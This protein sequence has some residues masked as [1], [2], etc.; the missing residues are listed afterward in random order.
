MTLRQD[1]AAGAA[2]ER[3]Y[4]QKSPEKESNIKSDAWLI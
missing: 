1:I 3:S 4:Q 2:D